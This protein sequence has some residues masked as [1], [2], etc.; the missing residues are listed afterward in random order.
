MNKHYDIVEKHKDLILQAE[1]YLWENPETGFKEYKTAAYLEEQ[2]I[3]LGYKLIKPDNLTGFYT[4]ADTLREGPTVLVLCEL[5][6]LKDRN[7]PCCDKLTGAVH[8]CGHHAQ[9]AAVLGLA[10]ALK[11]E[12]ALDGLCGRIKICAVPAEEGIELFERKEM[13]KKGILNFASGKPEFIYRGFFDDADIAFMTHIAVCRDKSKKF[14]IAKGSNGVLRKTV[15]IIGKSA[16]A[17]EHPEDG[18]NALN[19]AATVLLAINSLR[20]TFREKDCVRVHSIIEKGG[21]AVN[22]VP[23][24]VRIET[25]VRAAQTHVIK[26]V[27]ESVNRAISAAAAIYGARVHIEDSPGSEPL[28]NDGN[29]CDAARSV[30]E[31][32][33]GKGC[34]YDAGEWLASSTDMGDLSTLMP[35]LHA[36]TTG[37]SGTAHGDD[38]MIDDPYSACVNA[39]KFDLG[40][41]RYLLSDNAANAKRI[42]E[43]YKPVFKNKEKYLKHKFSLYKDK[44]TV[45]YNSDGTII[46]DYR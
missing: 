20:E 1:K 41:L 22:A 31:E 12:G 29:L 40:M 16:H 27:N 4:V 9:C 15:K 24:D 44:E 34:V 19:A 18:I 38:F 13:Q 25:Y 2:M 6:S 32:I 10:A 30:M 37:A 3:K 28:I 14:V 5:D 8:S 42:I 11:E 23:D 26:S 7:H 45:K 43:Q 33:G 46:I 36:Y 17:G 39:A 21:D 35:S